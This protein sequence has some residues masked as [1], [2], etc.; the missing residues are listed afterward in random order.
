MA[1]GGKPVTALLPADGL[2]GPQM[3]KG[4]CCLPVMLILVPLVLQEA[5]MH[6]FAHPAHARCSQT[7]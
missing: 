5:G 3:K 6:I 2:A 1:K 7:E 4:W